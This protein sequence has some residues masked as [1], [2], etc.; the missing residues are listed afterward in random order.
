MAGKF[1]I[2]KDKLIELMNC[3]DKAFRDYKNGAGLDSTIR[4][5]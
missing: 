3:Q 2:T 1:I 5:A 4:L